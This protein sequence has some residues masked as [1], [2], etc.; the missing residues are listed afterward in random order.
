MTNFQTKLDWAAFGTPD[1]VT[2]TSLWTA[3]SNGYTIGVS[4]QGLSAGQGARTAYNYDSIY[5]AP[6]AN[7]YPKTMFGGV[8]NSF[9]GNF[10]SIVTTNGTPTPGSPSPSDTP[11]GDHLMGF[12]GNGQTLNS[13][14][15]II[16]L[17][18]NNITSL[19]FRI[20]ATHNTSFNMTLRLFDGLSGGGN[21]LG[22]FNLSNLTGGGTCASLTASPG[23]S[24]VACN[25]ATFVAA[26]NFANVRSFSVMTNDLAGFYIDDL[27][28]TST[29]EPT[30]LILA[31]FGLIL[32]FI[33]KK[34]FTRA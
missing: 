6:L 13:T 11:Y 10:D 22:V 16:D 25:T 27:Y 8:P 12:V 7:W 5:F 29:P 30:P 2:Q 19:G 17:G 14:G 28:L 1:G 23:I 15:L 33:G 20:A 24:P 26:L 34:K 21:S 31:G 32:V 3:T 4:E 9:N 18:Q